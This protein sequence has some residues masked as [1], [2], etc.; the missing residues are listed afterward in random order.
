M[1]LRYIPVY[2]Q[3]QEMWYVYDTN[4]KI[5]LDFYKASSYTS[6]IQMCDNLNL[7][8]DFIKENME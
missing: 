5:L 1:L 3:G 8:W 2:L 7:G 6:I 4:E